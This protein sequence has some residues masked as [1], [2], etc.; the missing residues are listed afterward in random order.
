MEKLFQKIKIENFDAIQKELLNLLPD[1]KLNLTGSE[2]SS[3]I[4][5]INDTFSKCPNLST[6][7][8]SRLKK[9]IMQMKFYVSPAGVGTRYHTDGASIRQPFALTLP[10]QNTK[11]TQ[12]IWYKDD[13]DNFKKR[14]M[15]SEPYGSDFECK[16]SEIFVPINV[17][18]LELI[19]SCEILEPT[20]TRGD[21]M[22]RVI[23]NSGA[24]RIV[25]TIRWPVQYTEINDVMELSD[26]MDVSL[27]EQ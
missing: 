23:N 2:V 19:D 17:D 25:F 20:F 14:M 4:L 27:N 24:V 5:D 1:E 13:L 10:V 21:L 11:N 15:M 3:W 9:N 18:K 26:I 8:K 16:V 12:L 22:H 7:L 6:F